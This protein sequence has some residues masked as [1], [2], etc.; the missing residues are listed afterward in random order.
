M[1][2][3]LTLLLCLIVCT[4]LLSCNGE[5]ITTAST[6]EPMGPDERDIL[7][8]ELSGYEIIRPAGAGGS[9]S[10]CGDTLK[11]AIEDKH[12]FKLK[13][14]ADTVRENIPAYQIKELEILVGDTNREES[15]EFLSTLRYND[16]GYGIVNK[17]IV[18]AGHTEENTVKA[19]NKFIDEVINST[20][21]SDIFLKFGASAVRDEYTLD[22]LKIGEL[23]AKNMAIV[24][25]TLGERNEKDFAKELA[26]ESGKLC[27]L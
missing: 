24:Y 25:P 12:G 3:I 11:S 17:K 6:T 15:E 21:E 8:S 13:H 10:G 2:K 20:T 4:V 26:A 14:R 5:D 9:V 16:Y 18:I 27:V 23:S 22:D 7:I 1:K 19:M